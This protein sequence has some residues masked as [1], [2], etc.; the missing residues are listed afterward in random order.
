MLKIVSALETWY[1]LRPLTRGQF[2]TALACLTVV[3][4]SVKRRTML[5]RRTIHAGG[6][7]VELCT[8]YSEVCQSHGESYRTRRR[9][10]SGDHFRSFEL[11]QLHST[12]FNF[13]NGNLLVPLLADTPSAYTGSLHENK[14][15]FNRIVVRR[16]AYL[17][18]SY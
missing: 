3:G 16:W 10:T 7:C 18:L 15:F 2:D 5:I 12:R 9:R 13:C 8:V 14:P 17:M 11:E 4:K 6:R 1:G